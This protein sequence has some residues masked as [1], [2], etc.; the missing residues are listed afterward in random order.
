MSQVDTS[1]E[2]MSQSPAC[3]SPRC[4]PGLLP[5]IVQPIKKLESV[6]VDL[7]GDSSMAAPD[8]L[9]EYYHHHY[10]C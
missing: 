7:E 10:G 1:M 4:Q 8:Q 5:H 9:L 6:K 3:G 2:L